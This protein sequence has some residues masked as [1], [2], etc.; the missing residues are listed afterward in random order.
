M[1]RMLINMRYNSFSFIVSNAT[2]NYKALALCQSI[3][4]SKRKKKK[5]ITFK[6]IHV[7]KLTVAKSKLQKM[8]FGSTCGAYK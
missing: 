2:N 6:T 7:C 4:I 5:V 1:I 8:K 3:P